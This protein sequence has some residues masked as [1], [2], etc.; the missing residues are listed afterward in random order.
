MDDLD[1]TDPTTRFC[2][3]VRKSALLRGQSVA[4]ELFTGD[5]ADAMGVVFGDILATAVV[6]SIGNSLFDVPM[7]KI[8]EDNG[9]EG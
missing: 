7:E 1:L 9:H 5:M 3:S 6:G 4:H 8:C 2:T